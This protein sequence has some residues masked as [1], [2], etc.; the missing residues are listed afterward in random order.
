[1]GIPHP[2]RLVR[3]RIRDLRCRSELYWFHCRPGHGWSW[4]LEPLVGSLDDC[5]ADRPAPSAAHVHGYR[6]LDVRLHQRRRA[7]AGGRIHRQGDLALVLLHQPT[8]W[9]RRILFHPPVFHVT[10]YCSEGQLQRADPESQ[11]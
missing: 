11:P 10:G 2:H 7:A 1:M 3:S 9:R 6:N 5:Q 4:Y 8:L